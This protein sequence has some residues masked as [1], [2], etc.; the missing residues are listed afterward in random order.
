[1]YELTL[2]IEAPAWKAKETI[3]NVDHTKSTLE[4]IWPALEPLQLRETNYQIGPLHLTCVTMYKNVSVSLII[5][6]YLYL[7]SRI[8]F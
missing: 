2:I 3:I 5:L 8:S 6:K 7:S 4:S 1:M